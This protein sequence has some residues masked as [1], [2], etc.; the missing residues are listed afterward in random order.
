MQEVMTHNKETS[1]IHKETGKTFKLSHFPTP[2]AMRNGKVTMQHIFQ[3][4]VI[5]NSIIL[6]SVVPEKLTGKLPNSMG[7]GSYHSCAWRI[8]RKGMWAS[9]TGAELNIKQRAPW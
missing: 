7:K 6:I 2:I 5:E 9:M 8:L 4:E 1:I 3:V